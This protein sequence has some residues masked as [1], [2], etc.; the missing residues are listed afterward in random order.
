MSLALIKLIVGGFLVVSPFLTYGAMWVKQ[1]IAV[2]MAVKREKAAGVEVCNI[3]VGE[4]ENA[5][6]RAITDAVAKAGAASS[7]IGE[8]PVGPELIKL[9]KQ[10]PDCRSR[11]SL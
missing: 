9:C 10:S 1:Q 8:T 5:H 3:R 4:I 6:K 2:S 11:G 7:T